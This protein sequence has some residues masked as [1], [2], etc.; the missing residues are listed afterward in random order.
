MAVAITT[1]MVL[2]LF[3]GCGSSTVQNSVAQGE[4]I[5]KASE[6]NK[7]QQIVTICVFL[8]IP[9]ALLILFTYLP[10]ADM[11]RYSFYKWNGYSEPEFIG[12]DNYITL[13]T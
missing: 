3:A 13:F 12:V 8:T 11:I 6:R 9:L 4:T 2:S 7:L 1:A 5:T 10:L